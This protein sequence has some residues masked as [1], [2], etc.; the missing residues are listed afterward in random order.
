VEEEGHGRIGSEVE[1]VDVA[2]KDLCGGDTVLQR[3]GNGRHR[4]RNRHR[5]RNP[6][7]ACLG[8]D[9]EQLGKV[10]VGLDV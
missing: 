8:Q 1:F 9:L 5:N 6:S 4:G 10:E 7:R 3:G 2:K